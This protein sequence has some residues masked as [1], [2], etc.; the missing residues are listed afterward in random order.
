MGLFPFVC[1]T[2][3]TTP[4]EGTHCSMFFSWFDDS[5]LL[6]YNLPVIGSTCL[7]VCLCVPTSSLTAC[8]LNGADIQA[9]Y[10]YHQNKQTI[11]LSTTKASWAKWITI[12]RESIVW[13]YHS[14]IC[15][16]FPNYQT[17]TTNV[18]PLLQF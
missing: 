5:F 11:K 18:V 7:S 16:W 15:C 12:T 6:Q 4:H 13:N 14:T 9:L 8:L 2:S 3:W 10:S 17:T 1:L